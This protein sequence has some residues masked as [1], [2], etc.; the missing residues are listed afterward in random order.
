[1]F[2]KELKLEQNEAFFQVVKSFAFVNNKVPKKKKVMLDQ[3]M[4]EMMLSKEVINEI[5]LD[6]ALSIIKSSDEKV[7]NIVYFNVMRAGLID[8]EYRKEEIDFLEKLE[9]ELQISHSKK[10]AFANYFYKFSEYNP[11]N[12]E[13]AEVEARKII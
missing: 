2:L 4:N 6:Q 11:K 5:S 7:K 13:E 8:E 12:K 3:F 10:I 1:M 9:N